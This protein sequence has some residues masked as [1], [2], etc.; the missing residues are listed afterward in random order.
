M[1][2]Q[3]NNAR[4]AAF[5]SANKLN[6]YAWCYGAFGSK[7]VYEDFKSAYNMGGEL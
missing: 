2:P 5:R 6:F 3:Y 4:Q 1:H 7:G